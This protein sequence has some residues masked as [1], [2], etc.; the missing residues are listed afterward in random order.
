MTDEN[1]ANVFL[2]LGTATMRGAKSCLSNLN[3]RMPCTGHGTWYM[4]LVQF[5]EINQKYKQLITFKKTLL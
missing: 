3:M 4:V 5:E 2:S 1:K